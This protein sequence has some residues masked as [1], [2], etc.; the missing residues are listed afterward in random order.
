MPAFRN[1]APIR[2]SARLVNHIPAISDAAGHTIK[3]EAPDISLPLSLAPS[4]N[5]LEDTSHRAHNPQPLPSLFDDINSTAATGRTKR[6]SHARRR[7]PGHIPRP[8]NAFILFRSKFV[9]SAYFGKDEHQNE[10]S[11]SAGKVW[12]SMSKE[13]KEPYRAAAE[14]QK[15]E[16]KAKNPGYRYN[17]GRVERTKSATAAKKSTS[18]A[19]RG[20]KLDDCSP[21]SF[22]SSGSSSTTPSE[23]PVHTPPFFPVKAAD[24]QAAYDQNANVFDGA[25]YV[26]SDEQGVCSS[27]SRLYNSVAQSTAP[28]PCTSMEPHDH[29]MEVERDP[30]PP[31]H[32][33]LDPVTGQFA[34]QDYSHDFM[35]DSLPTLPHIHTTPY[36]AIDNAIDISSIPSLNTQFDFPSAAFSFDD[37]NAN[38]TD[39]LGGIS[40]GNGTS[41]SKAED[42]ANSFPNDC[43]KH[44]DLEKYHEALFNEFFNFDQ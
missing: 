39:L 26:L 12:N 19:K 9:S 37:P 3:N 34:Y 13:E 14:I 18:K 29:Q 16:H 27:L 23:S 41:T 11:R 28:N 33:H 15:M 6:P 17:P 1:I 7:E 38:C 24:E 30:P 5:G 10:L 4:T 31:F 22:S 25:Q 42:Q 2:H 36:E 40:E 32:P 8:C 44:G 20:R 21:L 35:A 43:Y